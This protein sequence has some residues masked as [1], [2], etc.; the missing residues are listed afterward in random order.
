[1]KL[2]CDSKAISLYSDLEINRVNVGE[3]NLYQ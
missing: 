2:D 3:T 1:M